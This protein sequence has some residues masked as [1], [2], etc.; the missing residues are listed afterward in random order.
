[1]FRVLPVHSRCNLNLQ[2]NRKSLQVTQS[3]HTSLWPQ[4][5]NI[6]QIL[7]IGEI[8][9]DVFDHAEFLGG[10]PL[11]FSAAAQRLGNS[12]TLITAVGDDQRGMRAIE[13]MAALGLST[14]F[15]Q[16]LP[17]KDTGT[18][19]VTTDDRGNASYF[20]KRP[21]V[22]DE[23]ELDD[24]R[25][26]ALEALH[27]DWLYFGTLAQTNR[28]TEEILHRIPKRVPAIQCFYDMNLRQGHWNLSLVERLS[29][30]AAIVKLNDSEAEILFRLS[31][32]GEHFSLERFCRRW[33]ETYDVKTI[34]VTLGGEG[35]AILKD[36]LFQRFDGFEVTVA[37]TVGAGD[38]F[39]AA[40]LHGYGLGLPVARI[41]TFA[42]ALGALV[43]S[44][45][46]ATPPWTVEECIALV[47]QQ[48][49]EN[50]S[51]ISGSGGQ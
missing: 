4:K 16:V 25:L 15:A 36:N 44:R 13:S 38:A 37:D 31:C 22:F 24:A 19:V 7:A 1:M 27:P 50:P 9:W 34:C 23:F 5:D 47:A 11:N 14:D 41:A 33:S 18:A 40:F 21:A 8:L 42:N 48:S 46:G 49:P 12:V 30:L 2:A 26:S 20:I 6:V 3:A 29:R 43:A 10:A 32:P 28:P 39:A 17:G 51:R 35:C 45:P